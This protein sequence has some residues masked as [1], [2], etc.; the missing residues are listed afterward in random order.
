MTPHFTSNS[1]RPKSSPANAA[2]TASSA[3]KP[4]AACSSGAKRTSR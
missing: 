4:G 1:R 3:P 2:R